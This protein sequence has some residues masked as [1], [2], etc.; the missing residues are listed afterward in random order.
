MSSHETTAATVAW[1]LWELALTPNH[2]ERIREEWLASGLSGSSEMTAEQ[3]D[4]LPFLDGFVQE[5]L[6]LYPA[7]PIILKEA[8]TDLNLRG[9][10]VPKGT[11]IHLPVYAYNR[12][13]RVW[14]P[15]AGLLLPERW[16]KRG[17]GPQA[18]LKDLDTFA[19]GSRS[20]L[21]RDYAYRAIKSFVAILALNFEF[22]PVPGQTIEFQKAA[23]TLRPSQG[24]VPLL[25]R[26]L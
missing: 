11:T 14:G 12:D 17:E 15:S 4:S 21:G 10:F 23:V 9:Q 22:R 25:V 19:H 7:V 20:C 16:T 2:Q 24:G 18:S 5:V 13:E 6:R 8:A 3:I 1:A 26:R